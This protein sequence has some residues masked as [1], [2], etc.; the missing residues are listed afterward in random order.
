MQAITTK[1]LPAT[2]YKG[3]R[4]KAECDRGSITVSYPYELSGEACHIW[5]VDQLIAKFVKEDSARYGS[6]Q[7]PWSRPRVCGQLKSGEY[8]HIFADEKAA[9]QAVGE[10][11]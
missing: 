9:C 4:I 5:A 10:K 6:D 8:A 11:I 3:S 2:N 1:F 7:N